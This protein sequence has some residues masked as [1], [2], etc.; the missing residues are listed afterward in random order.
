MHKLDSAQRP[1]LLNLRLALSTPTAS[2]QYRQD[3]V[4]KLTGA[5]GTPEGIDMMIVVGGFNSSNTSHLQVG[6]STA[7]QGGGAGWGQAWG[8][9]GVVL[10]AA[11]PHAHAH[12]A[13]RTSPPLPPLPCLV[14]E[15]GEMKDIPSFWVDSAARI[16]VDANKVRRQGCLAGGW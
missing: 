6:L 14:Q 10:M 12:P 9:G 3:A 11:T 7:H 8:C 15:I 16:D 13:Q 1:A 2:P 5:Q 4:Y